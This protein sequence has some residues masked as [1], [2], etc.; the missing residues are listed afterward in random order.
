VGKVARK[1]IFVEEDVGVGVT[2]RKVLDIGV[3]IKLTHMQVGMSDMVG[4]SSWM[5]PGSSMSA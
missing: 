1:K 2:G 3:G 5:T 4:S